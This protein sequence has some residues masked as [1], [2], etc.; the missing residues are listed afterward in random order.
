MEVLFAEN[1]NTV[2]QITHSTGL[3]PPWKRE[4]RWKEKQRDCWGYIGNPRRC[5]A[6]PEKSFQW[7]SFRNYYLS[8]CRGG[9]WGGV[10][11]HGNRSVDAV[12]KV[13]V[14]H[15]VVLHHV[16]H[17]ALPCRV[18][19]RLALVRRLE[20]HPLAATFGDLQDSPTRRW[21]V[22][23]GE[24][25]L[26][27]P[28]FSLLE[29]M[30]SHLAEA[31]IVLVI[32]ADEFFIQANVFDDLRDSW[33]RVTGDWPGNKHI[34]TKKVASN[35]KNN[36]LSILLPLSPHEDQLVTSY[37]N[38]NLLATIFNQGLARPRGHSMPCASNFLFSARRW[39]QRRQR[40][41]VARHNLANY[42]QI[43]NSP[44]QFFRENFLLGSLMWSHVGYIRF[45]IPK[46]F[47]GNIELT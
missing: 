1:T 14:H 37:C 40:D 41:D 38:D 32:T 4:E 35:A 6:P 8:W 29:F 9:V 2:Y 3:Q 30:W 7:L 24:S 42:R 15:P 28:L 17:V 20:H 21:S 16:G 27:I 22:G 39:W 10:A 46:G 23:D 12:G 11:E 33:G 36:V 13:V 19:R 34:Q 45:I 18:V 31:N 44:T 43:C 25:N 47:F 26:E 5:K